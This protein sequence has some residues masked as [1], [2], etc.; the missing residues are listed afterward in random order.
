[1][2]I[3]TEE[4]DVKVLQSLAHEFGLPCI[5]REDE[6]TIIGEVQL[7]VFKRQKRSTVNE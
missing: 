4:V 6:I 3:F 7:I 5:V 1:M 2:L